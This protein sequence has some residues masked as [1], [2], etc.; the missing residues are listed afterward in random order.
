MAG[1]DPVLEPSLEAPPKVP[2]SRKLSLELRLG[3][4]PRSSTMGHS[5]QTG[6][7]TATLNSLLWLWVFKIYDLVIRYNFSS[8]NLNCIIV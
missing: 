3:P 5:I 6:I 2:V 8:F 4:G 7:L 1:R